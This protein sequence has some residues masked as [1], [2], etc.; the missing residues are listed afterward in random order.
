MVVR[1]QGAT[2]GIKSLPGGGLQGT[3]LGLLLF[4]VLINDAGFQYQENDVGEHV[5]SRK[6]CKAANLLHLKYVD[7]MTLAQAVKLK[8]KLVTFSQAKQADLF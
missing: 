1:Y 5:A 6:N 2:S 8:D 4:L 3:L 7:D